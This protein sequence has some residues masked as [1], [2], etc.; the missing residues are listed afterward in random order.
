M[1]SI[2]G[3]GQNISSGERVDLNPLVYLMPKTSRK[4]LDI[5]D[6]VCSGVMESEE[7]VVQGTMGSQVVLKSGP[8]RPKLE[9]VSPMQWSGANMRILVEL[10]TKGMLQQQSIMDYIAYTVKVSELAESYMWQSVLAYDRAYRQLQAQHGFRWASD[11]PHLATLHLK[12][13]QG[14]KGDSR[15]TRTGA[16]QPSSASSTQICRLFNRNQCPFGA[17][18]RFR[19]ICSAPSCNEKHPLAL[20]GKQKAEA[21]NLPGRD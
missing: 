13:R 2:E 15:A 6:F 3:A 11:S 5:V 18:C 20:H 17:E 12:P 19:H 21:K 4:A 7:T 14:S 9:S 1:Q 10:L 8:K 16:T